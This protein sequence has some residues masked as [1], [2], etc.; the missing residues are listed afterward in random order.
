MKAAQPLV[1]NSD[2]NLSNPAE[3]KAGKEKGFPLLAVEISQR[4]RKSAFVLTRMT[5]DMVDGTFSEN[6]VVCRSM[7]WAAFRILH[8][9]DEAVR[10]G[11]TEMLLRCLVEASCANLALRGL[12]MEC[13]RMEIIGP[14]RCALVVSQSRRLDQIIR[15]LCEF[16]GRDAAGFE[17][18]LYFWA[19]TG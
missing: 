19:L 2:K 10:C 1:E 17:K 13:E 8:W 18:P 11:Q 5:E 7:V 12:L 16:S 6:S 14:R 4:V 3:N 15:Q 9:V